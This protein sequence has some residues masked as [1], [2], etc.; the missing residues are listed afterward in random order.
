[1]VPAA[2][3]FP[4]DDARRSACTVRTGDDIHC[5][6]SKAKN[7]S[8]RCVPAAVEV[9]KSVTTKQCK[10]RRNGKERDVCRSIVA[11]HSRAKMG[12]Q[13]HSQSQHLPHTT[14]ILPPASTPSKHQCCVC[15]CCILTK[16]NNSSVEGRSVFK[17]NEK[18]EW[19]H[20][21]HMPSAPSSREQQT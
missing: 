1:M 7:S 20:L 6:G 4:P 21:H 18:Q 10:L 12:L 13:P 16:R 14:Y 8:S 9:Y 2:L 17:S 15:L 5:K 3:P 11:Q 19:H